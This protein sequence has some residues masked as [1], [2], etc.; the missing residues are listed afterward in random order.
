MV[1]VVGIDKGKLHLDTVDIVA[2]EGTEE[3]VV[4]NLLLLP[5]KHSAVVV[6]AAAN[7]Q[8]VEETMPT[9]SAN[10]VEEGEALVAVEVN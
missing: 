1:V 3:V 7:L 2:A 8:V 4:D 5:R 6:V 9:D 10:L